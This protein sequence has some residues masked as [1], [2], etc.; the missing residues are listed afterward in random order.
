MSDKLVRKALEKLIERE[1]LTV[2]GYY[3]PKSDDMTGWYIVNGMPTD[4]PYPT[5]VHNLYFWLYEFNVRPIRH[6]NSMRI[7]SDEFDLPDNFEIPDGY[8]FTEEPKTEFQVFLKPGIPAIA[9]RISH[10]EVQYQ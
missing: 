8:F 7:S 3:D 1:H 9:R 5:S 6:P 4:I 2:E 10:R